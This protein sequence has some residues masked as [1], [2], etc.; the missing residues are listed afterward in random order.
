MSFRRAVVL[1]MLMLVITVTGGISLGVATIV[2][3][4]AR[5]DLERDVERSVAIVDEAWASRRAL[6]SAQARVV[7]EEPRLKATVATTEITHATIVGVAREINRGLGAALFLLVDVDGRLLADAEHGHEEGTDLRN[8]PVVSRALA[9]GGATGIVLDDTRVFLAH[10]ERIAFGEA[11]V[12]LL[13]LG[14]AVDDALADSLAR[15]TGARVV[16]VVGDR[17][18][19]RSEATGPV[20]PAPVL[21]RAIG[22]RP[23]EVAFDGGR[24]LAAARIVE[25][26][27]GTE[28]LRC[29]VFA[30]LDRALEP[31]RHLIALIAMLGTIG[32]VVGGFLA[33]AL[34]RGL[35]RPL[36]RMVAFA[37][38]VAGGDLDVRVS[39]GGL[40]EMMALGRALDAMASDLRASQLS[41]AAKERMEKELEIA[42]RLQTALLPRSLDVPGLQIA[43]RM[44]TASEIGG[45]YYDVLRRPSGGA[46][47]AIGDVAGHGLPAGIVMLMVRTALAALVERDPDAPPSEIVSRLNR[48]LHDGVRTRLRSDEH[49][50]FC[51]LRHD[52]AGRFLHAGAHEDMLLWRAATQRV[53]RVPTHG[54][55]LAV[56]GDVDSVTIDS[57]LTLQVGDVLLLLT[58][59]LFEQ[60]RTDGGEIGIDAII[61]AIE[62][63]QDLTTSTPDAI[64][65]Q[66]LAYL[67]A[68][69][70]AELRDDVTL[71][72]IRRTT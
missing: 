45:D 12:G 66:V 6:E 14:S 20:A 9:T 21:V 34:S 50:T 32:I 49:V 16:F 69:G 58:D 57:A 46:W 60:P 5:A 68:T 71:L 54:T 64:V 40:R 30:S 36:D 22:E 26:R 47:I 52:G 33:L 7:A 10:G 27:E 41:L 24:W 28:P 42:S 35:S 44:L 65:E 1:A 8:L 39:A 61:D 59:G 17:I 63:I 56:A 13:V 15:Q 51:V 72:V 70:A 38:R 4:A 62:A 18:V 29:V 19:A 55:W 37:S 23:A 25:A 2:Q 3:R 43:A 67:R 53:M 11:V 31:S 48:L